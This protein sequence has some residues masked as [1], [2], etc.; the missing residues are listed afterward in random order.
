MGAG[1]GK[2][3]VPLHLPGQ[4]DRTQEVDETDKAAEVRDGLGCFIENKLGVTGE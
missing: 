4:P 3:D 2:G 1:F